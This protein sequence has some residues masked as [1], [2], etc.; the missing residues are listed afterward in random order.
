[1]KKTDFKKKIVLG[2]L[3]VFPLLV[4]LFFA[5]GKNNFAKLPVLT[6]GLTE[7][8]ELDSLTSI[9]FKGKIT[10]L[11]YWGGSLEEKQAEALNL[12]EKIIICHLCA[13]IHAEYDGN[14]N[15]ITKYNL[16]KFAKS[17]LF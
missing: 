12:N 11:G 1:M 6:A 10:I 5:S 3:F 13:G 14:D 7:I 17:Y 4:Y 15:K 9:K 16:I 8:S 2:I